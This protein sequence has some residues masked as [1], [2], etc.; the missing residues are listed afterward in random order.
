MV[1]WPARKRRW[2]HGCDDI[3]HQALPLPRLGELHGLLRRAGLLPSTDKNVGVGDIWRQ[4]LLLHRVEELHSLL[5]QA[6]LLA[7]TDERL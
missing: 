7:S 2:K 3:W 6:A 4:A 5:W 1:S